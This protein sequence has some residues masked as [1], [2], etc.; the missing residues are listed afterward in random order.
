MKSMTYDRGVYNHSALWSNLIINGT[1]ISHRQSI[2]V[3]YRKRLKPSDNALL[4][5]DNGSAITVEATGK[6]FTTAGD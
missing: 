3:R 1:A 4:T 5:S 2:R 6:G